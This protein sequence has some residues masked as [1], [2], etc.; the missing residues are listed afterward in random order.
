MPAR[1][2]SAHEQQDQN[3]QQDQANSAAR[4][5]AIG[6]EQFACRPT[7]S[8]F[9][10]R[11]RG[12]DSI[13]LSVPWHSFCTIL[14]KRMRALLPFFSRRLRPWGNAKCAAMNTTRRSP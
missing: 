13:L 4:I 2:N 1:S 14:D 5:V 12:V 8:L 9:Q 10:G 3:N 7:K 6:F 11:M